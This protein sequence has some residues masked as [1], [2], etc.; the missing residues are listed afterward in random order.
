MTSEPQLS[1]L[2]GMYYTLL[3]L[4]AEQVGYNLDKQPALFWIECYEDGLGVGEAITKAREYDQEQ[5]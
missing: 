4:Y 1:D 3:V 5:H 2:P